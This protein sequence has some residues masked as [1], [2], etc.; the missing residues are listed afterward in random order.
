MT[1]KELQ[2]I[3]RDGGIE[4][5]EYESAVLFCKYSGMPSSA[6][7]LNPEFSS[8][9]LQDAVARRLAFEP[10]QYIL[11]ECEFYEERY[12]L[13]RDC[14][15]PRA[16]TEII[17]E[18]AIKNLPQNAYFA[19]L[20]T[21]SGCIAISI[22]AHRPDCRAI[23]CDISSGALEMAK[24]NAHE[25]NV[26]TRIEFA[27]LD[28]LADTLDGAFDAV[29]SNPPYIK[30]SV[31][32][33]LS[34][35]VMC[36]PKLALD[37]GEDGM[38]FY[39]RIVKEYKDK[40]KENGFLLFETGYDQKEDIKALSECHGMRCECVNDYGNNHRMAVLWRQ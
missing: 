6:L 2:K 25:N 3:L 27:H 1:Y 8:K 23:A 24:R 30:S 16:D 32:P 20:C 10:L 17:V 7:P 11:G 29:I 18:Y 22:L 12:F 4:C 40:I 14:L 39:K 35:E 36:E 37:G 33:T 38:I 21:G 28:V 19:D 13:S 5:P 26:D 9:E 34:R 31:M 15:I